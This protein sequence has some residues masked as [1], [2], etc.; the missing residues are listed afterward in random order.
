MTC[1][2]SYNSTLYLHV[3]KSRSVTRLKKQ[4]AKL[5]FFWENAT[6]GWLIYIFLIFISVSI[7]YYLHNSWGGINCLPQPGR[8]EQELCNLK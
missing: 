8:K 4:I 1:L 6:K 3:Q 2:Y 5:L 7:N